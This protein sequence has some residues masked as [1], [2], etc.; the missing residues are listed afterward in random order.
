MPKM[1]G[2]YFYRR[3]GTL[4]QRIRKVWER[5]EIKQVIA[6]RSLYIFNNDRA[7]ELSELWVS[8]PENQKTA[9]FGSNWGYY[10]GLDSIKK[11]YEAAFPPDID[12]YCFHMPSST[13]VVHI[14]ADG[15]T[16]FCVAYALASQ[17]SDAGDGTRGYDVFDR[18]WFDMKKEEDGWKIW[19]MFVGNDASV[20]N[21][22]NVMHYPA[23]AK[24]DKNSPV[25]PSE[26]QFGKPDYPILAFDP[27]YGW[28]D[29]P[30]IPDSHDS[31]NLEMSCGLEACLKFKIGMAA[32]EDVKALY[33]RVGGEDL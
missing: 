20:E 5:E 32:G 26:I 31:Y 3:E 12:G 28:Y 24:R 11:Y 6:K 14:A 17:A 4:D 2:R 7:S 27:K 10:V 23:L 30:R 9:Q 16:A 8:D 13:I 25:N 33:E 1:I 18:V 19:H 29:F 15:L 22:A 21:A